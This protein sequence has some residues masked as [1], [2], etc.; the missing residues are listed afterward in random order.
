MSDYARARRHMVDCQLRPNKVLDPAILDAMATVPRERFV[1][2]GLRGVAYVDEDLPIGADRYLM[3]PVVAA[4]LLQAAA[5]R[6]G[7]VALDVGCGTGYE[8][9]V[10]ARLAGAVAALEGDRALAEKAFAALGDLAI[11]N[12]AVVNGPPREGFP[13]QA[14]YDVIF[15]SGAVAEVP[16]TLLAQLAEG[17]R[18]VGVVARS[19][20][21]GRALLYLRTGE[22]TSHRAL[23]DAATP[24]LPDLAPQP[25]FVF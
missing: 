8:A 23:F 6:P 9:A 5:V 20:G 12:V 15:L 18:L 2:R 16:E 11:D 22:L 3:E 17:G 25:R 19:G 24:L 7:D 13:D 4:R 14:P 10:L 1:P 21:G